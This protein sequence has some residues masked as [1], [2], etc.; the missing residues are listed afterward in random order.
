MV[1]AYTARVIFQSWSF[2]TFGI[3]R[4]VVTFLNWNKLVKYNFSKT[5]WPLAL[6][7]IYIYKK[8]NNISQ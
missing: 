1:V 6:N 3:N 5:D 8:I 7:Y 2:L 4:L